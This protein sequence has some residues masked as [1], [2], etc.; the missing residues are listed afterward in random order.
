MEAPKFNLSED[1][2]RTDGR[3]LLL[4]L[5]EDHVPID[6]VRVIPLREANPLR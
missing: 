6:R 4:V 2:Y 5:A 3:R 1:P